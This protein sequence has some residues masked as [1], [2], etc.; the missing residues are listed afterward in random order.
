VN[1][2]NGV[3][4]LSCSC[5]HSMGVEL[6]EDVFSYIPVSWVVITAVRAGWLNI[7]LSI[8]LLHTVTLDFFIAWRPQSSHTS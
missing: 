6:H 1:D 8:K 5:G 2:L 3:Q 7:Y 4:N